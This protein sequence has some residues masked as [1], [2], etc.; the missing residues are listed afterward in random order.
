MSHAKCEVGA[1]C[2]LL[3][4]FT[5]EAVT[6][7]FFVLRALHLQSRLASAILL[8]ADVFHPLNDFSIQ[9]LL[10]GYM[11]HRRS[12][13]CAMPMLL[14]R[15]KPDHIARP[16]FLDRTAL[17]LNPPKTRRDDQRL[18]EWM[19]MP[20]GV[21]TR[22]ERDTCATHTCRFGC[23]EQRINA[24]C[25]GK[26]FRRPFAGTLRTRSFYLHIFDSRSFALA[27][28][29]QLL[30]S[31][32]TRRWD[33]RFHSPLVIALKRRARSLSLSPAKERIMKSVRICLAAGLILTGLAIIP[34]SMIF[35]DQKLTDTIRQARVTMCMN[36]F[37]LCTNQCSTLAYAGDA[38]SIC[39]QDC[40]AK[41]SVCMS[42]ITRRAPKSEP[43]VLNPHPSVAPP[44]PTPRKIS[45]QKVGEVSTDRA[46]ATATPLPRKPID[47]GNPSISTT[48]DGQSSSSTTITAR[49]S[50]TPE[51]RKKHKQ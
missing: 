36:N 7:A 27:L 44:K 9:S 5:A 42:S 34:V 47:R 48:N 49:K 15:R 13:T 8:I 21:S 22:L 14:T 40:A 11:R 3:L 17:A 10:N 19:C 20:G 46:G 6:I 31:G 38:Y 26:I 12:R 25:A 39:M 50:P 16:N 18:T 37:T 33:F 41:Y 51:P 35:G 29:Y 1:A 43:S 2:A 23:L 28:N 32:S 45:P 24:N 4:L 30:R